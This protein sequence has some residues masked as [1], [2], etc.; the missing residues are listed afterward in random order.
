MRY[1][2]ILGLFA[3]VSLI[4]FTTVFVPLTS[5]EL[6]LVK[7]KLGPQIN[8]PTRE[9]APIVSPDGKILYFTR[10][11]YTDENVKKM[12]ESLPKDPDEK[13]L[14][15]FMQTLTKIDGSVSLPSHLQT[16]WYSERQSDGTWGPA[17]LLPPPVN[18]D[19][20]TFIFTPLPDNNTLFISRPKDMSAAM[21]GYING[22]NILALTH[23]TKDGWSELEYLK[24]KEFMNAS[25]R[26][27]F[28]LA[29][30]LK[31]MLLGIM[32][33]E[34]VGLLDL[35]VSFLQDDGTWSRPKNLG[36]GIN[37]PRND[38]G[39]F[40]A[41][42]NATVY[43][44]SDREGGYGLSDI[45]MIRRLDDTWLKWTP[46]QNLGPEINTAESQDRLTCD[47]T[48]TL[49]FISEGERGKEDIYEFKLQEALR[50]VPVALVRGR[51]QDPEKRPLGASI[52]YE[53]LRDGYPI[54]T[55]NSNPGDGQYQIALPL[56]EYYGFRAGAPGYYSVSENLDL[57]QATQGQV[58]E[59]NLTLVPIKTQTPIRLNNIF[60]KS[61]K[62]D[63]LPESSRELDR[64]VALLKQYP[65]MA[66]EIRGHTD[67]QNTE[68]YNQKLSAAR[69]KSVVDYLSKAG[70]EVSRL[71]SKGFGESQ[72]VASNDTPEGRFLNRRVEFVILKM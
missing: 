49:A 72:P 42:D 10:E 35:Y 1:Q 58:F 31:V 22:V 12:I 54:G 64:L 4:A 40:I 41:P 37:S 5:V 16:C 15:N 18:S 11:D 61:D 33:I 68:E 2:K 25:N 24:F 46:P 57:S 50:P 38:Y 53:R 66:I 59:R 67:S 71:Q 26:I 47:A 62:A 69:A 34:T 43:F 70:I 17:K 8:S 14:R 9:L 23:R 55:A 65:T 19:T 27:D 44:A 48:G 6:K 56:K 29:P 45:Y 7:V 13:A 39:V 36:P 60:F 3:T 32:N 28:A 21:V 30:S 20:N 52:S 51:V 63:L